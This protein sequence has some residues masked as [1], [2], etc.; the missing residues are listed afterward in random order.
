MLRKKSDTYGKKMQ[1]RNRALESFEEIANTYL[2]TSTPATG[3]HPTGK[4]R[5]KAKFRAPWVP[6]VITVICLAGALYIILTN[7]IFD[8]RIHILSKS[9]YV[10]KTGTV[11][12]SIGMTGTETVLVKGGQV[13]G[14]LVSKAAFSGDALPASK[15]YSS[16]LI[17]TNAGSQGAA[18]YRIEFRKPV[19]LSGRSL[20]YFAKGA[21]DDGR[22]VVVIT[23]TDNRTYR[24]EDDSLTR[25]YREWHG[26]VVTFKPPA[27][28]IDLESIS[29]IRFEFGSS[30]V[31]NPPSTTI[32]L[33]DVY[34]TKSK[35]LKW[36]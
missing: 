31:G 30:T 14:D 25:L 8:V 9:P 13:T 11:D 17:L 3:K 5:S 36:L 12:P 4:G 2:R 19:D 22:L 33:R 16:E 23:D 35:R 21:T 26:Y 1:Q 29:S 6:W 18:S 7:S 10:L 28:T 20:G 34:L 32:S 15:V 27:N 24:V